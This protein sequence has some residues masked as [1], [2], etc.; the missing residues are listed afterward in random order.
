MS[1]EGSLK[2]SDECETLHKQLYSMLLTKAMGPFLL[3]LYN[4]LVLNIFFNHFFLTIYPVFG[5]HLPWQGK[6]IIIYI[7]KF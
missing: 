6:E 2:L 5:V 4:I 3:D 7:H 1:L